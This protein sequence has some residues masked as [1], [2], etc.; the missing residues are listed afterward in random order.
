[1]IDAQ[2]LGSVTLG[3]AGLQVSRLGF[4][5]AP[6]GGLFQAVDDDAAHRALAAAWDRGIRYF[7]TAPHYGAG[8][9]ERRIGE[10]LRT[11]QRDQWVISTKVGRLIEPA[12]PGAADDFGFVGEQPTTRIFDF[13]AAGVRRSLDASLQ[14]LGVDRVDIA[15]LHDPDDFLD[16]AIEHAWPALAK[17]RD[18]GVVR[19]VGAG[20]NQTPALTRL[21]QETDMDVVLVAGRYTLL[22]QRALEDLFPAC[23]DHNTS[24]VV[25]G[26][27]NSGILADPVN[28]PQFD[29]LPASPEIRSR[30][31]RLAQ[32]CTDHGVPIAAA[33]LQFPL[34]HP[35]VTSIVVGARSADEV[36]ENCKLLNFPIP[37]A[38]WEQLRAESLL[39]PD[40]PVPA[41]HC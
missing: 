18:E 5:G 32:V 21:V 6:L 30:A 22:D 14:R 33:A 36:R 39:H 37:A 29:Y 3:R 15:F 12:T 31:L 24:V 34:A 11:Q 25:G 41:D 38:L 27:F 20:M 4:G 10:F 23:L 26:V 2:P 17:L 7:D 19:S 35:A 28:Q 9:S 40:T 1:V 8:R 13:S 16:A